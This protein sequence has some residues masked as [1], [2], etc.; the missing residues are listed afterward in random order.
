M[1]IARLLH[2]WATFLAL[3]WRADIDIVLE[4]L[5]MYLLFD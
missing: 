2:P 4:K 1:K 3:G 5:R